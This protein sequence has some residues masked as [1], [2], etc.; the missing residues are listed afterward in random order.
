MFRGIHFFEQFYIKLY[1]IYAFVSQMMFFVLCS[2]VFNE[3]V[4]SDRFEEY[5]LMALKTL[6]FYSVFTYFTTKTKDILSSNRILIFHNWNLMEGICRIVIEWAKAIIVVICLRE[7]G[8]DFRPSVLYAVSTFSYY[9]CTEKI[10]TD[11]FRKAFQYCAFAIFDD[12]EHLIKDSYYNYW[13][14][15]ELE[16][17]TFDN[18]RNA[19][20]K[21]LDEYDDICAAALATILLCPCLLE[22][23]SL[24]NLCPD[25]SNNLTCLLSCGIAIIPFAET[26]NLFTAESTLIVATGY[27]IFFRSHTFTLLSSEPETTLSSLVNTAE[28]TL[29]KF[30]HKY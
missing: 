3:K 12:L 19:S 23:G 11:I 30:S 27:L 25:K 13:K 2:L 17:Q 22:R 20:Q 6:L 26:L 21:Q 7:Q 24:A 18:F 29:L 10:F 5:L 15:L 1:N 28:V 8:I 14:I 16:K 4:E 9:L